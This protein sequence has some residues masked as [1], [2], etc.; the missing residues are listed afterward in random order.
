MM[1]LVNG[2]PGVYRIGSFVDAENVASAR[3]LLKSG[4]IE[5]ARLVRWFR[6]VNQG[7]QAKDCILFKVP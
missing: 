5:E 2:L 4:L 1:R 3:V 6:F 7:N